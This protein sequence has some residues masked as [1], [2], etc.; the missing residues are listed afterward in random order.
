[1]LQCLGY[2]L[3]NM[4]AIVKIPYCLNSLGREGPRLY[5]EKKIKFRF[6]TIK[7]LVETLA[8]IRCSTKAQYFLSFKASYDA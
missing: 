1:M 7:L 4:S 8:Q 3:T 5:R 2:W 6:D